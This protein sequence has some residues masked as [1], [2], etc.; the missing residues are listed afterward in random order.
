MVKLKKKAEKV[1]I[2]LSA[3]LS[4][5][6]PSILSSIGRPRHGTTGSLEVLCTQWRRAE[7]THC[8]L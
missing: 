7:T 5:L 2:P 3:T 1:D 6:T 8:G 4:S